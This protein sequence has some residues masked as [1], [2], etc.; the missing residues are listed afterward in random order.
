M[1]PSHRR[2]AGSARSECLS[3]E[4]IDRRRES[5]LAP[6]GFHVGSGSAEASGDWDDD[7]T[8]RNIG[9]FGEERTRNVVIEATRCIIAVLDTHELG[10]LERETRVHVSL[11]RVDWEPDVSGQTLEPRA[12]L[13]PVLRTKWLRRPFG[14]CIGMKLEG[15]PTQISPQVSRR[16]FSP[17]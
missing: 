6:G 13:R 3:D 16:F 5:T 9:L 1:R 8:F 4:G 17:N 10:R 15:K 11:R 14:R 12:N 7:F 2:N